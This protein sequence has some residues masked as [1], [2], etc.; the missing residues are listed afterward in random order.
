MQYLL[1]EAQDPDNLCAIYAGWAPWCRHPLPYADPSPLSAYSLKSE[2]ACTQSVLF[3][4]SSSS[5]AIIQSSRDT[6]QSAACGPFDDRVLVCHVVCL[7]SD[8]CPAA[9][10]TCYCADTKQSTLARTVLY[11]SNRELRRDACDFRP[12]PAGCEQT[13]PGYGHL[14]ALPRLFLTTTPSSC[15][16]TGATCHPKFVSCSFTEESIQVLYSSRQVAN[17]VT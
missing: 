1:T 13:L 15:T 4:H 9:V 6:R 3:L 7:L 8:Y 12:P 2:H 10:Y 11:R 14:A 17:K 16:C 5:R